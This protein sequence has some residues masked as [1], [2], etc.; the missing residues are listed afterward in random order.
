MRPQVDLICILA[1]SFS[2]KRAFHQEIYLQTAPSILW[3]KMRQVLGN[4]TFREDVTGVPGVDTGWIRSW[5]GGCH[6]GPWADSEG[7]I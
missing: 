4:K 5:V 6:L 7:Q 2:G 1:L 3:S